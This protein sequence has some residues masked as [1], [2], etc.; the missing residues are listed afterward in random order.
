MPQSRCAYKVGDL[1]TYHS[2]SGKYPE[3]YNTW[4]GANIGAFL[5]LKFSH[6]KAMLQIL[7]IKYVK[8]SDRWLFRVFDYHLQAIGWIEDF[9][10]IRL[11]AA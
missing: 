9:Y 6:P 1:V 11:A 7:E 5:C 3:L 4:Q 8:R 2:N 10:V